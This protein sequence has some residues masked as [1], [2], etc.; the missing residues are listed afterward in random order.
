MRRAT[1]ALTAVLAISMII[2]CSGVPT[3]VKE[4]SGAFPGDRGN[5]VYGV[6]VAAPDPNPQLQRDMARMNA[7]VEVARST[8]VYAAELMKQFAQKHRDWF[9]QE[10]A[11]SVEFFQQA[12]KQVTEATLLGSQEISTWIDEG[13]KRSPQGTLYV[14]MVLPL[15]NT[16]FNGAQKQYENAV[17][18]H[19]AQVLKKEADAVL[20]EL[21]VELQNVRQD[22]FGLTGLTY[23]GPEEE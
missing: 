7:R 2:G 1:L 20:Q 23:P 8:R 12:A 13:G 10:K 19:Q 22:P 6:G 14:L 15:D 21:N 11:G 17:R 3:W 4:G 18:R 5:A 9:D 16:F